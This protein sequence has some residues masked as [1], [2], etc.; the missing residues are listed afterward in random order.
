MRTSLL[1]LTL[2]LNALALPAQQTGSELHGSWSATAGRTQVFWGT[3][4]AQL[5]SDKPNVAEG[6]WALLSQGGQVLL[7]GTWSA[8]KAGYG[9]QGAWAARTWQGRSLSGTW[10]ADITGLSGKTLKDMLEWTAERDIV[11]SWRRSRSE[12]EWRLKG[13]PPQ[14][15][16]ERQRQ[17]PATTGRRK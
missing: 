6:S 4:T 15:G 3:W 7:E 9:W 2:V 11:G 8:Q 12:G 5:S 13:A 16:R 14:R 10:T 1:V 17:S